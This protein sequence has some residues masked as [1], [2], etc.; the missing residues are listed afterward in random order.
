MT[1]GQ[2]SGT[3]SG[4]CFVFLL[5]LFVPSFASAQKNK[6]PSAPAKAPAAAPKA[7]AAK[8]PAATGGQHTTPAG[9][10]HTTPTGGTHTTPTG[11]TH[12]TP[13][14]GTHTTP[15][16]GTH[17][18]PT[19]G[20]HTTPT[21]ASGKGSPSAAAK[22]GTVTNKNGSKTVTTAGG[23]KREVSA[24]GKTTSVTTKSGATAKM[25]ANGK[26]TSIHSGNTT[27]NHGANGQRSVSTRRAD[28][29]RVVTNGRHGGYVEHNFNRGG[30]SYSR[31]TYYRDGHAY[32]RVY[33][34]GYYH[35]GY[36]NHYY[37]G[38]YYGRGYYGWAYGGWGAP[39]AWSWGW[40]GNPWYGYY[41]YYFNPFPVYASPAFWITDYLI[42]ANL[43]AAYAAAAGGVAVVAESGGVQ[44]GI[45]VAANEQWTD[46]GT[47]V[48]PGQ[49]YTITGSG[50]INYN[51]Q[52]AAAGPAGANGNGGCG[53]A[54]QFPC[55]SMIGKIGPGGIPF[56]VGNA[57]TFVAPGGGELFLGVNDGVLGDNSGAWVAQVIPAGG[58]GGGNDG[59]GQQVAQ[60]DQGSGGGGG[61]AVVLTPEVKQA[62]ADEV[63]A[64]LKAEQDAAATSG[65]QGPAAAPVSDTSSAQN[66][67]PDAPPPAGTPEVVPDALNPS[68]RTFI[69]ADALNPQ[70]ADGSECSLTQGDVLT[71]IDDTPDAN[72]N[73]KVMVSGSQKGDCHSG[74]MVAVSVENLQDMHNHFR[75]QID[76]GLGEMAKKQGTG[77]MPAAP[78][79]STT[80]KPN[81]EGQASPD[82]TAQADIEKQN[83]QADATEKEVQV[84][85]N[86]GVG[87]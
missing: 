69:V 79:G 34:R 29:S 52:G 14:G 84:A 24:S 61:G 13:T 40:G 60:Q 35:G 67:N 43:Q 22:P 74:Q 64:Q 12:T 20:A 65:P 17:T 48:A 72:Q 31:R 23:N 77:G 83:T 78:A 16:G 51:Q 63:K 59:G 42:A 57:K 41:G 1:M 71:R 15:T 45:S 38:A 81:P 49:T 53:I 19:G 68:N 25:G 44:S 39:V 30:R 28:G 37:P 21:G 32:S 55:I 54:P 76:D 50:V 73:V 27:I 80:S 87:S 86:E 66:A 58:N 3:F 5:L 62:I 7:P 9:G 6:A 8:A 4:K 85:A 10:S 56:Y 26:V 75:E 82:L 46:T 33:G 18:A 11:G 2:P 36:Y 70:L 47:Q